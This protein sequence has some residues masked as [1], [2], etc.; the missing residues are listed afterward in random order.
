MAGAAGRVG[1]SV[2]WWGHKLRGMPYRL[3]VGLGKVTWEL[4]ISNK[5]GRDAV[6]TWSDMPLNINVDLLTRVSDTHEDRSLDGEEEEFRPDGLQVT[7]VISLMVW[8]FGSAISHEPEFRKVLHSV[9][10]TPSFPVYPVIT[11]ISMSSNM[12][13]R[14]AQPNQTSTSGTAL[15]VV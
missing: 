11:S 6:R 2:A 3:I 9:R 10:R 5:S 4:H 13:I 12:Q 8:K 14:M 1:L 7:C 15:S